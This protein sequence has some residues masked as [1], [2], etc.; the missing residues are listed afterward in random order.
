MKI[1]RRGHPALSSCAINPMASVLRERWRFE[2]EKMRLCED[3]SRD[4]SHAAMSQGHQ[5]LQ[6]LEEARKGSPRALEGVRLLD[7]RPLTSTTLR[8][9]IPLAL[10]YKFETIFLW[11]KGALDI[12]VCIT[13]KQ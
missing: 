13:Y 5:S 1:L 12:Y 4:W 6:K 8:E 11:P 2:T 10:S 7:F 3:K 9:F